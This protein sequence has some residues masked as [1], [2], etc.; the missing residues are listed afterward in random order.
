MM[1]FSPANMLQTELLLSS[2][3]HA[4]LQ[5]LD[6]ESRLRVLLWSIH[7]V[8]HSHPHFAFWLSMSLPIL[9]AS[10]CA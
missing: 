3:P 9:Q 1:L 7:S 5:N 4:L 10:R 8:E 6:H 2:Q